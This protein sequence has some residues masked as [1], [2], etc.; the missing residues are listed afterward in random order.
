MLL[1]G[2]A[3]GDAHGADLARALLKRWP[4]AFLVGTG[5]PLMANAG[6]RLEAGLDDLAVMGFV[7]ILRHLPFFRRLEQSVVG[8]LASGQ[9]DLVIPIDYPGFN[10][11]IATRAHDLRVPV[12]FYIAPQ[13]WAWR[14]RR[15]ARLARVADRVAVILPFEVPLLRR[16]GA[17]VQ[18]VGHPL[19]EHDPH[20][21]PHHVA[22]PELRSGRP[23]LALL[24]GSRTQEIRRHLRPMV[25]A[26]TL[27]RTEAPELQVALALAEGM[28]A[29]DIPDWLSVVKGSRALLS[30][31]TA[32]LVKSGTSTL[33]AAL[34][35]VPFVCMYRTHPVTW[36]LAQ[37]LVRVEHIALANLVAEAR[38][39]PE[40]LQDEATGRRL[41]QELRPLLDP[42]SPERIRLIEGLRTVRTRLGTPGAAE[43]V[44]HL[45]E[46]ILGRP[47]SAPSGSA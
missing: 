9:V 34:A 26:A 20:P 38:V 31:A 17:Q 2:E 44:A 11:R 5:G 41:A 25:D 23:L 46:E 45:A 15:A 21:V 19:L 32:A 6:V 10:L 3:S 36:R 35:E 47:P 37:R 22:G 16:Y 8:Q 14:E 42:A 33:E 39:V 27:L 18:F 30:Q 40:V 7:E 13:V 29:V 28:E 24:P 1:A 12:L 4:A 43:R